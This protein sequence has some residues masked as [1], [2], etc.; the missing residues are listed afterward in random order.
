LPKLGR[1][2]ELEIKDAAPELPAVVAPAVPVV[3]PQEVSGD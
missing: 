2:K 3:V 1:V